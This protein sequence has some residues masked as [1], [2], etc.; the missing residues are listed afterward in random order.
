M[1][2]KTFIKALADFIW[3]KFGNS[4][5]NN[6]VN[7]GC[8]R[9]W[10]IQEFQKRYQP[11]KDER[12]L[13][14]ALL[15]RAAC[16]GA[17]FEAGCDTFW[18]HHH[19][20]CHCRWKGLALMEFHN[21]LSKLTYCFSRILGCLRRKLADA[22]VAYLTRQAWPLVNKLHFC[23]LRTSHASQLSSFIRFPLPP[24]LLVICW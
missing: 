1:D 14:I 11:R 7:Y 9:V 8:C 21:I 10:A 15:H 22:I 3:D 6:I 18:F 13:R 19:H 5:I 4:G 23:T 20:H 16:E 12:L 17:S 24:P 2:Q